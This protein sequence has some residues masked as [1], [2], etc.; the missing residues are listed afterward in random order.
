[1]RKGKYIDYTILLAC[2]SKMPEPQ[3]SNNENFV[4]GL[5]ESMPSEEKQ[6]EKTG[7]SL[8]LEPA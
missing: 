5:I 8:E 3:Q 2:L 4:N 1:M 7:K 6:K